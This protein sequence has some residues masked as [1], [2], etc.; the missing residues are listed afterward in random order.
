MYRKFYQLK[1]KPFEITPDP[2]FLYLTRDHREALAHLIYGI[3][4]G[5]GLTVITGQPGTGKT[6]LIHTLLKYMARLN[7]NIRSVHLFNPKLNPFDFLHYLCESLKIEVPE[8]SKVHFLI[9]LNGFLL[10]ADARNEKIVLAID[11]A[12]GL[13]S[14]VLEEVRL[15]T[16]FE[17]PRRKLLQVILMGQPELN[18]HLNDPELKGLKQ[19]ITLRYQIKPLN[20]REMKDYIE[21]RLTKAGAVKPNIFASDAFVEI[22]RFSKGIPRLINIVCDNALV[23]GYAT[24]QR[25][26]GGRIIK[27]VVGHLEGS[28]SEMEEETPKQTLLNSFMRSKGP[29]KNG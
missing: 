20:E 28:D 14:A 15:L 18:E 1:E 26:I 7:G 8:K 5:K 2:R 6:T 23:T 16:N 19:R 11:E 9:R 27:E 12:Q 17:T 29:R 4:E 13:D 21:A 3:K 10:D 24:D 25:T 22:Y